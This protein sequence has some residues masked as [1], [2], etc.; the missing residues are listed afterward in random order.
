L[1]EVIFFQFRSEFLE[2]GTFI[3]RELVKERFDDRSAF[4]N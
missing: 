2:L 4:L 1:V 3:F